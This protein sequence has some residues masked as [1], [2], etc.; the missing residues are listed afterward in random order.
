MK[1]IIV[2]NNLIINFNNVTFMNIDVLKDDVLGIRVFYNCP[3]EVG[4][5]QS[6]L[7][8]CSVEEYNK[9]ICFLENKNEICLKL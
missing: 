4:E 6:S 9:I 8:S 5:M 1:L 7:F 3:N 2:D